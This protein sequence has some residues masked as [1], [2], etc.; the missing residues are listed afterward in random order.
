MW[1]PMKMSQLQWHGTK[2]SWGLHKHQWSPEKICHVGAAV[3][4]EVMCEKSQ[5]HQKL[6]PYSS[7][8][9]P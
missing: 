2:H 5:K 9:H 1:C 8:M 6:L 4:G 7:Q 3:V